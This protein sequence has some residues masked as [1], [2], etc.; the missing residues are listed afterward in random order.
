LPQPFGL[1]PLGLP[2]RVD[3]VGCLSCRVNGSSGGLLGRVR[4]LCREHPG[5]AGGLLRLE[6]S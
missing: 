5:N 6:S 4:V 2:G 1:R 3:R